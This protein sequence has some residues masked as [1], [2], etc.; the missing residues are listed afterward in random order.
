MKRKINDGI[1]FNNTI[2]ISEENS[3]RFPI[4]L[5]LL[6]ELAIFIGSYC[7]VVVLANCFDLQIKFGILVIFIIIFTLMFYLLVI[8]PKYALIKIV[9]FILIYGGAIHYLFHPLKN[10]FF[11]L[12][13]AFIS[14]ASAYYG[15]QE[16]SFIAN[17][18]TEDRDLMLLI[19]MIIIPL[20]GLLTLSMIRG[21]LKLLCYAVMIIPV[22][23]SFAMGITPPELYLISFILVMLFLS[24][25]NAF[26][27]YDS[28][29]HKTY[30]MVRTS[31]VYR[32][33]IRSA[34]IF[35]I[36]TLLLF[37]ITK[38]FVTVEKYED[39]TLVN[40][41]KS[42]IQGAMKDFNIADIS[43]KLVDIGMKISSGTIKGGNGGLSLGKLGLVDQVNHD[44]SEH[45]NVKAPL[46]SIR[47]GLYLKG[48]VGSVYTGDQWRTHSKEIKN[49]YKEMMAEISQKDFKTA[50]GNGIFLDRQTLEN[51]LG[52][53]LIEISYLEANRSYVYAPYYTLFGE[54]DKADFEY[55]LGLIADENLDSRQFNYYY[56]LTDLDFLYLKDPARLNKH[57]VDERRYRDFV[58]EAYTKLPNQGTEKIRYDFSRESV[59]KQSENLADAINYIKDYLYMN[60]RY[61]LSPGKLP[62]DKDFVEYFLY[63]SKK[64]YCSHYASAGALML[65]AMGYP[66]RYVEGYA[67]T[68]EDIINS[69]G[70]YN[71]DTLGE[72]SLVEA[73]ARDYNAHAWV[74]V[75]Y[76]EFG[77]IPVEFTVGYH[78]DDP[79][80]SRGNTESVTP[81][82]LPTNTPSA[83]T[84]SPEDLKSL[85]PEDE[86]QKQDEK[87]KN[88]KK[89]NEMNK[90]NQAKGTIKTR[91]YIVLIPILSTIAFIIILL[92]IYFKNKK[93]S[94]LKENYS[95]RALKLY[96]RIEKLFILSK[97]FQG[98]IKSLEDNE[99][100]IKKN[101]T[102][103]S[104]EVFEKCMDTIKRA[105]FGKDLIS[106]KEYMEIEAFYDILW[107]QTY[108]RLPLI[109]KIF[110]RKNK[111]TRLTI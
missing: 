82:P 44:D 70:A 25:S 20:I 12:E 45:L 94:I 60:T 7:F 98:N 59:G 73:I 32:T 76:D 99:E 111:D 95:K 47:A 69:P 54:K 109:K 67:I 46:K 85:E 48:Y 66:A 19:I 68:S 4:Y 26:S 101:Y 79:I 96:K 58:Y 24:I 77:W 1:V 9:F 5:R 51:K 80:S 21:R 49:S 100:Y 11:L 29:L 105:R 65:R 43:D 72:D 106:L 92:Y 64:G 55:D 110:L 84:K 3:K 104:A 90:A 39:F 78:M 53:G 52:R 88:N 107:E 8:F 103:I 36:F 30:D 13:N 108:H 81:S 6:Q 57:L 34:F 91:W 83:P 56:N 27:Q 17:Y 93:K 10:G 89:D 41:A 87:N 37:F 62:K 31:I 71:I 16:F 40:E 63:E 75:Y 35:C 102:L 18:S 50:I 86:G 74:E 14:H 2:Y 33:S 61:T 97:A 22:I 42:E 38:Q 28:S 15:F 23:L